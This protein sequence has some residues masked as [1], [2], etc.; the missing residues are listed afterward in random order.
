MSNARK[1][2]HLLQQMEAIDL[3]HTLE[4]DMPV[5]PSHSRYFHTKWDSFET[6][7]I[8]L[9]NQ[10]IINEHC[11]THMDATAHFLKSNHPQH[12]Y[13]AQ[14][15][16]DQFHARALTLDFTSY[17]AQDLVMKADIE[18]WEA[19]N[20]VIEPGDAVIFHFGWDRYWAPRTMSRT[21]TDA[22]PGLSGEAAQY[23]VS[24][25][26]KAVGCDT[27][28]IDSST[29]AEHPAHYALLGNGIVII[30]N[31]TRLGE[32]VGEAYLFAFPLKIKNGS[33]SPIRAIAFKG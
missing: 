16:I 18:S 24:K 17:Q 30:E 11:G 1:L 4:E 9:V 31:L 21:Y 20:R 26:V 22:W 15:P 33:G 3:T 13:M 27:L 2:A 19:E 23:L 32:I 10:L 14:I 7:S 12:K 28:A 8:A 5:H 25:Q 6:G 29:S